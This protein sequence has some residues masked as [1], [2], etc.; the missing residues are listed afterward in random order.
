MEYYWFDGT[1]E[2]VAERF[3]LWGIDLVTKI[4][5]KPAIEQHSVAG[6]SLGPTTNRSP[7]Y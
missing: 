1:S 4:I 3:V 5:S 2:P 7:L 6:R